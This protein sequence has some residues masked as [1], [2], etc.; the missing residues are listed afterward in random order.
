MDP[1]TFDL[2]RRRNLQRLPIFKNSKGE[3]AHSEPDGS[4]WTPAQ[5][6]QAMSGE[7]GEYANVRKKFERGDLTEA[8]FH[9]KAAS[10]LADVAIYLDILA[11]Q[12]G[13]NLGEAVRAKWDEVSERIGC[14]LR[15][16]EAVSPVRVDGTIALEQQ[17]FDWEECLGNES[18][19][20]RFKACKL[21][22]EVGANLVGTVI[23]FVTISIENSSMLFYDEESAEPFETYFLRMTPIQVVEGWKEGDELPF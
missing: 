15:M 13:V 6:Y 20:Q 8:E 17:I 21:L 2:L 10:E 1:L 14:D 4:D 18:D 22:I 16:N 7:A 5:W 12:V 19:L 3:L 11:H 23:P 9:R